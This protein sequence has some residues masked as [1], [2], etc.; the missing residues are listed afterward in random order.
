[1]VYY[2]LAI[3]VLFLLDKLIVLLFPYDPSYVTV[4]LVP[5]LSFMMLIASTR[6]LPI[7]FSLLLAV[8]LG[9]LLDV[10][11]NITFMLYV[12]LLIAMVFIAYFWGRNLTDTRFEDFLFLITTLFVNE[13]ILFI[14]MKINGGSDLSVLSWLI[15]RE[16]GTLLFNAIQALWITYLANWIEVHINEQDN[17]RRRGE[18][19]KWLQLRLQEEKRR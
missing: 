4:S 2:A 5:Y 12:V 18:S 7:R 9:F 15:K 1:M 19:V 6:K 3:F 14:F 17:E 8:F 16:S 11:G 10:F 13:I